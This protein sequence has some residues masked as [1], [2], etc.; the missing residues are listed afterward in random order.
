M[1]SISQFLSFF[2]VSMVL[3]AFGLV[4][5][6]CTPETGLVTEVPGL[7]SYEEMPAINPVFDNV[8]VAPVHFQINASEGG[9]HTLATGT[10]ITVPADILR[11]VSGNTVEGE[12][13]LSFREFHD[14]ADLLMSGITMKYD[15]AGTTYDFQTAGMMEIE[16]TQNGQPLFIKDGA[17]I[18]VSLATFTEEDNYNLYYLD[19]TTGKWEYIGQEELGP[20]EAKEEA[21]KAISTVMPEKP[22]EPKELDPEEYTFDFAVDYSNYPELASFKDINWEYAGTSAKE[23]PY[24]NEWAFDVTWTRVELKEKNVAKSL[25]SLELS[26]DWGKTFTTTVTPALEGRNYQQAMEEFRAN[27][28]AYN[29]KQSEVSEE[30][31][32]LTLQA[33]M[34]RTFKVSQFGV[35]NCDR[36]VGRRSMQ[37]AA[38]FRF[39]EGVEIDPRVLTV[40]LICGESRALVPY[41]PYQHANF[42]FEPGEKN[43][44]V[45]VIPGNKVAIFDE[46]DFKSLNLRKLQNE[47]S[48]T[49]NM[50][51]IDQ[52]ITSVEDLRAAL[53]I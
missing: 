4:M 36:F 18:D 16:A 11:D 43:E 5:Q 30:S 48:Y 47:G 41:A 29:E 31:K 52:Q 42:Q 27:L 51:T 34:V 37:L 9:T 10:R 1:K 17:G 13:Q 26:N 46:K 8:D 25:Y 23:D 24:Q 15:S 6:R 53:A 14:A 40:Y 44:L 38:N 19:E 21:L 33:N 49:F 32:R 7:P 28:K 2:F 20:N 22:V 3:I 35:Y 39:E 50:R 12:V 45:A